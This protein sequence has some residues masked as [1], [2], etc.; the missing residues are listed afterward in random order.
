MDQ[1][2]LNGGEAASSEVY[3]EIEPKTVSLLISTSKITVVSLTWAL[4]SAC[5][6]LWRLAAMFTVGSSCKVVLQ[7]MLYESTSLSPRPDGE[8][9]RADQALSRS[10][11]SSLINDPVGCSPYCCQRVQRPLLG[12][13]PRDTHNRPPLC[14]NLTLPPPRQ[15]YTPPAVLCCLGL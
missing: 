14:T 6:S 9:A 3:G 12:R 7:H 8:H 15:K 1:T 5:K 11:N 2:V 4:V 10:H 13:H